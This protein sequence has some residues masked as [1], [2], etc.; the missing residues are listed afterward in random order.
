MTN[1]IVYGFKSNKL[2][3]QGYHSGKAV[4]GGDSKYYYYFKTYKKPRKHHKEL[5]EQIKVLLE[6]LKS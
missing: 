5:L 4:P 2:I 1:I 6:A 3:T